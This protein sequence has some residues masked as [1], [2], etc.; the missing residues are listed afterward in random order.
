MGKQHWGGVATD[1]REKRE[2]GREL[3]DPAIHKAWDGTCA[4]APAPTLV[5]A[6]LLMVAHR[7]TAKHK[8]ASL[9]SLSPPPS[10]TKHTHTGW[11][12]TAQ[13]AL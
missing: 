8:H 9:R 7:A 3:S 10:D 11:G 4:V 5:M 13:G 2:R 1:L 6:R 12:V